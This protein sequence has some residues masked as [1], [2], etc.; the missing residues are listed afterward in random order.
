VG[1]R[2]NEK[3]ANVLNLYKKI[4]EIF[5]LEWPSKEISTQ[6]YFRVTLNTVKPS[7]FILN[8]QMTFPKLLVMVAHA[9]R[10]RY[11]GHWDCEDLSLKPDHENSSWDPI[12]KVKR[13]KW[14]G[15]EAQVVEL[16]LCKHKALSSNPS[17]NYVPPKNRIPRPKDWK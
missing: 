6:T 3:Y 14:T 2:R 12:S 17:P 13:T 10:P 16:L 15:G 9:H 8:S 5:S 7:I 1:D 11:L 4:Q